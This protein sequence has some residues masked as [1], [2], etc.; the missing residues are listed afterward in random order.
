MNFFPLLFLGAI[1]CAHVYLL[2]CFHRAL[3]D[4]S[5]GMRIF[6][7]TVVA[8]GLASYLLRRH[9]LMWGPMAGKWLYFWVAFILVAV[10]FLALKDCLHLAALLADR[11]GGLELARLFGGR[12]G[13]RIG[14]LIACLGVAYSFYEAYAV[15]VTRQEIK[16]SKLPPGRSRLRIVAVSDVHLTRRGDADRLTRLV[17][18]INMQKP[19]MV[20]ML[21]DLV[22]DQ[23]LGQRD[24]LTELL[25]VEAPLGRFAV[26]GNHERYNDWRQ[27]ERF[28]VDAGFRI[29][30]GE[31]VEAGGIVVAGVDDP[32]F[33]GSKGIT[34][35]LNT[36]TPGLFTLLLAHR[37]VTP[38]DA[39]GKFDLQLSGHTHGGQL[40]PMRFFTWLEFR[41]RQGLNRLSAPG[42][43]ESLLYLTNGAGYW[44]PPVRFLAPPEIVV[45]DVVREDDPAE[46]GM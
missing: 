11:L 39:V 12:R 38:P 5:L 21:G 20:V 32:V 33:H 19:D 17:R 43:G 44:G 26:L 18:Q 9:V 37:P 10:M 23:L 31:C 2:W 8:A 40:R 42:G 7:G 46:G 30:R 3:P 35:T 25:K 24:L 36:A 28:T 4:G 13:A 41:R 27:A 14:L 1:V 16:T 22:D 15:G 34:E 45:V 29:L 6:A